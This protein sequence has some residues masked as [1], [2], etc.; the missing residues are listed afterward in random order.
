M[1]KAHQDSQKSND[2]VQARQ[3]I[4]EQQDGSIGFKDQRPEAT[5]QLKIQAAANDSQGVS[6]LG[7]VQQMANDQGA[8]IQKKENNTGLP[9]N[10]KSGVESLSGH[11]MDDVK[12]HYNSEKP[13][14]LNAHA[15]AQ[16]TNIHIAPGQEKHLPHEAWHV[17]QQKQG[18][19]KPTKQLKKKVAIND[20]DSLEKE[21]DVMGAK[22][23]QLAK[24]K[25]EVVIQ[26]KQLQKGNAI[27]VQ[28]ES[29]LQR[30]VAVAKNRITQDFIELTSI[31]YAVKRAGGPV[32][33]FNSS[34]FS[35]MGSEDV[36][37]IVAHGNVGQSGDIP[38]REMIRR[39]TD[40]K[41]GLKNPIKA[42]IFTSC[43]AGKGTDMAETDSVV[44]QLGRGLHDSFPGIVII[45]A[46]GPSGKS[47]QTGDEFTVVDDSKRVA[48]PH[49][50]SAVAWRVVQSMLIYYWGPAE[51]TVKAIAQLVDPGIEAEADAASKASGVFFMAWKHAM[52]NPSDSP[53]LESIKSGFFERYGMLEGLSRKLKL[54]KNISQEELLEL[55][56]R[57]EKIGA[58]T[59]ERPM[60][61][62]TS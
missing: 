11:S 23:T 60:A 8:P 31:D 56:Y 6:R 1:E 48:V 52:R 16:G 28:P 4:S 39:L 38:P 27:S 10:L 59:L 41:V 18:R 35:A 12:V 19:V 33:L 46:R 42:I 43:Y 3:N 26:Q 57:I 34:D 7:A 30:Q 24:N 29:P 40:K 47:H 13:A 58:L 25:S 45:G 37:Y 9:D 61:T 49:L 62:G 55:I 15:Y 50:G 21:A 20:D 53:T 32:A 51:D 5:A 54:S 17:V 36:L 2:V 22:A 44:N 14:Q